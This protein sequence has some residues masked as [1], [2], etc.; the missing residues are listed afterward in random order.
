MSEKANIN[1]N[2]NNI[3]NA[4]R[5]DT[6]R[7]KENRDPNTTIT[8]VRNAQKANQPHG[9][10]PEIRETRTN[11]AHRGPCRC[12]SNRSRPGCSAKAQGRMCNCHAEGC[13]AGYRPSP[14]SILPEITWCTYRIQETKDGNIVSHMTFRH[15]TRGYGDMC[16]NAS[17]P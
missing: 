13:P 10:N 15:K 5:P 3:T 14:N 9:T 12:P 16:S 7:T 17:M 4:T 1:A 8:T 2:N 11:M 6:S